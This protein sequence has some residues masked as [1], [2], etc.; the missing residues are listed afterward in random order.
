MKKQGRNETERRTDE[1]LRRPEEEIRVPGTS[2]EMR[3]ERAR[4][5]ERE[6]IAEAGAEGRQGRSGRQLT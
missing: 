2:K 4:E 6:R 5:K 1:L 3:E